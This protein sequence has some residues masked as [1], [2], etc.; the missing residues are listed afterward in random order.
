MTWKQFVIKVEQ[1]LNSY[2]IDI[3]EQPIDIDFIDISYEGISEI[4]INTAQMPKRVS[5]S[6]I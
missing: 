6:V 3:N 1:A 2:G 5:I 4:K